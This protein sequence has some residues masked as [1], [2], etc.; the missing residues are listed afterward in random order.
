MFKSRRSTGRICKMV[1]V[2]EDWQ[3]RARSIRATRRTPLFLRCYRRRFPL[4]DPLPIQRPREL[5]ERGTSDH[6]A[7]MRRA[8]L[9]MGQR[10]RPPVIPSAFQRVVVAIGSERRAEAANRVGAPMRG[11]EGR[12]G[13]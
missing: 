8:W 13:V 9:S 5:R 7:G 11:M 1:I 3:Q 10:L 2:H 4:R 6:G 12:Y